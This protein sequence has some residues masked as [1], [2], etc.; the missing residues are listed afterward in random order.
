MVILTI[1]NIKLLNVCKT[2][3]IQRTM[4]HLNK[5]LLPQFFAEYPM[6]DYKE[7]H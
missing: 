4:I 6:Q 1:Y 7:K 2:G 5:K 3:K